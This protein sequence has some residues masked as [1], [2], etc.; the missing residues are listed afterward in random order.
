MP[1][2]ERWSDAIWEVLQT[3]ISEA[4]F[5]PIRARELTGHHIIEDIWSNILK[6][7]IV[8]ADITHSNPNVLYELGIA[9]TLGKRVITIT[10]DLE[11]TPFDLRQI[12]HVVYSN[13]MKGD[14]ELRNRLIPLLSEQAD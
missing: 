9:H 2:G 4:G 3:I 6:A 5:N 10:Q 7:K 8:I 14:T 13:M 12:R 1:F 11:E